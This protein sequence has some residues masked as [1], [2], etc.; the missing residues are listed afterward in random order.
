MNFV[1]ISRFD[2]LTCKGGKGGNPLENASMEV[3]SNAT[4]GNFR[5]TS[6]ARTRVNKGRCQRFL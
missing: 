1:A 4:S 3:C 5:D 6:K 2:F